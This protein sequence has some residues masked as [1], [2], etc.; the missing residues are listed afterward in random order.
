MNSA[1]IKKLFIA[2]VY[3]GDKGEYLRA[4]NADRCKVQ[5]EWACF[6]DAL[7]KNG[8]ITQEQYE[9]ATF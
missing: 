4:R 1:Q 3:N 7:C 8:E 5:F 2:E 6:I 9:R